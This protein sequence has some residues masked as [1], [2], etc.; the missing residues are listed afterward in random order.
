MFPRGAHPTQ[1]GETERRVG[2]RGRRDVGSGTALSTMGSSP[3]S[4]IRALRRAPRYLLGVLEGLSGVLPQKRLADTL[5]D[6]VLN[7]WILS[8]LGWDEGSF[9]RL[10]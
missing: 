2:P 6:L 8:V 7:S 5:P 1:I 3:E 10:L 9:L 4:P